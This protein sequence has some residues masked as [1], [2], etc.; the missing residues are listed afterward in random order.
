M[1]YKFIFKQFNIRNHKTL[2][3]ILSFAFVMI[4]ETY[5]FKYFKVRIVVSLSLGL[6]MCVFSVHIAVFYQRRTAL[7]N[8]EY[9]KQTHNGN[10]AKQEGKKIQNR[11]ISFESCSCRFLLRKA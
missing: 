9:S 10:L 2:P 3:T 11:K 6:F 5:I 4:F 1:E 8:M 7:R